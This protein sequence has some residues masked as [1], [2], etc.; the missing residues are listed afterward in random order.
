MNLKYLAAATA[1]FVAAPALAQNTTTN[2]TTVTGPFK[3]DGST[4]IRSEVAAGASATISGTSPISGDGSLL[5]TGDKTRVRNYYSGAA[6]IAADTLVDLT[7][8]YAVLNQTN[9]SPAFRVFVT[10]ANAGYTGSS[11]LIWE[12]AYNLATPGTVDAGDLFWRQIVGLGYDGTTGVRSGS[13]VFHTLAEWGDILGGT[14]TGIGTGQGS[15]AG[16]AFNAYADNLALTTTSGTRT[17][18]FTAGVTAAVPEPSTWAMMLI[19]FGAVGGA[20]RR[21]RRQALIAQVA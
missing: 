10:G 20:M 17:Y 7:A 21:K 11:E 3:Q 18:N 14:V 4:F 12:Q 13:Y 15:G 9:Q 6:A 5:L 2:V 16:A 8:D 19:G 1:M